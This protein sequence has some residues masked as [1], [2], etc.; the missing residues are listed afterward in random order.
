MR[1]SKFLDFYGTVFLFKSGSIVVLKLK[2]RL[3]SSVYTYYEKKSNIKQ[4]VYFT[5]L[6]FLFSFLFILCYSNV[7]ICCRKP[8]PSSL[9]YQC[10]AHSL[11]FNSST[12]LEDLCLSRSSQSQVSIHHKKERERE[13]GTCIKAYSLFSLNV[14]QDTKSITLNTRDIKIH[15]AV[16]SSEGLKTES[17]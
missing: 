3:D 13:K 8:W 6:L 7:Y 11:W 14:N 15:S 1:L 10:Q 12:Q 4:K 5:T 16:L 2:C 9:A 17:K